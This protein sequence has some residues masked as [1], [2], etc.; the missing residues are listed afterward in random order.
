LNLDARSLTLGEQ[1]QVTLETDDELWPVSI[2]VAQL[3]SAV[4]NLAIN[5]RDAM[6]DGGRLFITM[7]NAVLDGPY[8]ELNPDATAGDYVLVEVSD[9][10][11]GMTP[12]VT[13][14]VFEPF[15]TTKPE[16]KGTGLGLSMVYGFIKQSGGHIKIYS[17][18]GHGTTIRLY[19]PRLA[20]ITDE[21]PVV[22]KTASTGGTETI[23][24]VEDNDDM[25]RM[26]IRQLRELGYHTLE[27]SNGVEALELI[28]TGAVF[29]LLFSDVV[30]P[31]G[32]NGFEL[33]QEARKH[34]PDLRI[35][36]T[37]G[38]PG[39]VIPEVE[40]GAKVEL[41]SKPYRKDDLARRV[42][43]I[44]DLGKET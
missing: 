29:D 2:D 25:R 11:T 43:Q 21:T 37:S 13:R 27:A 39:T 36:F 31:G 24:V 26:A 6:P 30:M 42:R 23:L 8:V 16:G 3:E 38:F 1:I 40:S 28:K 33:G 12:E 41:I 14:R 18:V 19:L 34:A 20:V 22:A 15:Y 35:L 10:G 32:M 4:T 9:T 5:A 44:L 7:G 17:E